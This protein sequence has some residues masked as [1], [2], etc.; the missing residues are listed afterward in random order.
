MKRLR[1]ENAELRRANEILKA[2]SVDS[3][4]QRKLFGVEAICHVL[5]EHGLAI[6]PSTYY[7]AKNRPPSAR[8]IRDTELDGH[9]RRIHT[10]NYGVYGAR[11]GLVALLREGRQV[12]GRVHRPRA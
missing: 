5:T 10:T 3:N 9:I 12:S 6:S 11:K 1:R 8:A 4:D 7:A 2:A